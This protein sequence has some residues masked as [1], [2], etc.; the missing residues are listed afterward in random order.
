[1]H[2]SCC[3]I[4]ASG[5]HICTLAAAL[6]NMLWSLVPQAII[7]LTLVLL[8]VMT[9]LQLAGSEGNLLTSAVVAAHAVF[10]GYSAVSDAFCLL[11]PDV[12]R[13]RPL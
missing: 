7:S 1:M 9:G 10:L 13:N 5:S 12:H 8:V 4:A 2:L 3:P 11:Q 6:Y